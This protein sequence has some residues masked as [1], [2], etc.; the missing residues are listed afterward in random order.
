MMKFKRLQFMLFQ[1]KKII[2]ISEMEE[3]EPKMNRLERALKTLETSYNPTSVVVEQENQPIRDGNAV[4]TGNANVV[5]VEIPR[6]EM[7]N[8]CAEIHNTAVNS[9][10]GD[11]RTFKEALSTSRAQMWRYS[12]ISEVNNCLYRDAW[13]PRNL[14]RVRKRAE[15]QFL[16]SGCLRL[17]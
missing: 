4:V 14:A 1:K 16:S 10:V 2:K 15:N 11:P 13:I 6:E 8:F 5:P 9:D 7:A 17:N 12:M 3:K